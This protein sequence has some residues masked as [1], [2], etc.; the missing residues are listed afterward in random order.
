[1]LPRLPNGLLESQV[2]LATTNLETLGPTI[3]SAAVSP[4]RPRVLNF[5]FTFGGSLFIGVTIL[6]GLAAISAE[7]NMLYVMFG[8]SLGALIVSGS[9]S[10]RSIR[11]LAVVREHPHAVFAGH[12]F[13]I[14][15]RLTNTRRRGRGYSIRVGE[16]GTRGQAPAPLPAVPSQAHP[17]RNHGAGRRRPSAPALAAAE[18]YVARIDAGETVVA[19]VAARADRR[20]RVLLHDVTVSTRF[21]FGL[22]RK[23]ARARLEDELFVLPAL[24][25]LRESIEPHNLRSASPRLRQRRPRGWV[26]EEFYGL[27]EYRHGDNPKLIHWRRSA[28][29]GEWVVR[30]LRDDPRRQVWVVLDPHVDGTPD[31]D[32]AFERAVQCAATC[33]VAAL[34]SGALTGLLVLEAP[35]LVTPPLSGV[36]HRLQFLKTLALVRPTRGAATLEVARTL[37]WRSQWTG[38]AILISAERTAVAAGLTAL[39]QRRCR[40][41]KSITVRGEEFGAFFEPAADTRP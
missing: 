18:G 21:P 30:E 23:F 19:A 34:E 7:A 16:H 14:Q 27:R 2:A 17:R 35:P 29:T 12:G 36:E 3:R 33:C 11:G 6:V 10:A 22:F 5:S 15:Y 1:M 40:S 8:L 20:G 32:A 13:V 41:V 28:R 37:R 31:A 39:M 4:R 26:H 38:H 24:G 25:R 9:L